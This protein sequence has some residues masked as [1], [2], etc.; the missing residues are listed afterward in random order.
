MFKLIAIIYITLLSSFYIF[1]NSNLV[2]ILI[3]NLIGGC[4]IGIL[5]SIDYTSFY[6]PNFDIPAKKSSKIG[7]F[8]KNNENI[9]SNECLNSKLD[10]IL[11]ELV[12]L[13]S[14]D[15]ILN[16]LTNLTWSKNSKKQQI[17]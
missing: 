2:F 12:E 16:W 9:E 17:M 11:N 8:K 10:T 7:N 3:T 13:V 1:S 6:I 5:F 15:F 14:R 4:F